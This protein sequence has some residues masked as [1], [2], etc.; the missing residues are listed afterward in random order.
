MTK[1]K[2]FAIMS[3][4]MNDIESERP[5]HTP[6]RIRDIDTTEFSTL[7]DGV[8]EDEQLAELQGFSK[9]T[10]R[11]RPGAA[12][13]TIEVGEDFANYLYCR[14]LTELA[15]EEALDPSR[16]VTMRRVMV[17]FDDLRA[18]IM[19]IDGVLYASACVDG[20]NEPNSDRKTGRKTYDEALLAMKCAIEALKN[21]D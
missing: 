20:K 14:L 2:K 16:K 17:E 9:T 13:T 8:F 5:T 1:H 21:Q 4:T 3:T 11:P 10:E 15:G 19:T 12:V 7:F 18:E 6:E